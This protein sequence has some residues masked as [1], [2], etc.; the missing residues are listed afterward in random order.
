MSA[1]WI[2]DDN[3][4]EI[5]RSG[6]GTQ[7]WLVDSYLRRRVVLG[8]GAGLYTF[9]DRRP[10]KPHSRIDFAGLVTLTAGYRFADR[11]IARVY[12][13]RTMTGNDRDTDIVVLGAGYRWN[14]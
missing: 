2:N 5:R 14:E 10:I 9:Y 1:S 12:W 4:E 6:I 3:Q 11:W 13:N 7:I 8:L